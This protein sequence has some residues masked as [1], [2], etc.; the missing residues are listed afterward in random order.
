MSG[1]GDTGARRHEGQRCKQGAK[2]RLREHERQ[3]IRLDAV[4]MPLACHSDDLLRSIG[5]AL[6]LELD[7][8]RTPAVATYAV[9]DA[10]LGF[11]KPEGS[12]VEGL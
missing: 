8:H 5:R 12:E 2:P 10:H 7:K 6:H 4:A 1:A 3:A 11:E 9:L